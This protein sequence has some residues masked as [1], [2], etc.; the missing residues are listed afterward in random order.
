MRK[1]SLQTWGL[2]VVAAVAMAAAACNVG[3]RLDTRTFEI[4]YLP[5][6]QVERLISPYVFTDREAN[7]GAMSTT[8]HAVTVRETPDNLDKIARVLAQFD[9]PRP[10]VMLHFQI[11]E[12]DGASDT[13]PAIADVEQEL[14]KVFRFQGYRLVAETQVQGNE[15]SDIRQTVR[16][17]NAPEAFPFVIDGRVSDVNVT[18]NDTTLALAINVS[19]PPNNTPHATILQT[20]VTLPTGHSVVLGTGQARGYEGALILVV[21]AEV[22]DSDTGVSEG[23]V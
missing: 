7:P 4:Q 5:P 16:D 14:R 6:Y 23:G 15:Y 3:P 12:A 18:A 1:C 10:T 13:D 19:M 2:V 17:S 21:R 20:S 9:N 11:I 22:L 8:E